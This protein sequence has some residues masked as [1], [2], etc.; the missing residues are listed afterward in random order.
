MTMNL[1]W[2]KVVLVA[3]VL[4]VFAALAFAKVLSTEATTVGMS[5]ILGW[6]GGLF[7]P[8]PKSDPTYVVHTTGDDQ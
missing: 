7:T 4:A 6:V 8:T 5:A 1:D 3:A 2:K